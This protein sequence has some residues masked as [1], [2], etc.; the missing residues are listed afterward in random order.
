M[1]RLAVF[2]AVAF[3]F[4][5]LPAFAGS[6]QAD[7][8]RSASSDSSCRAKKKAKK[9]AAD[10]KGKKKGKKDDKKPYGFEL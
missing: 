7:S 6:A 3:V 10:S 1:K 2:L 9:Q 5:G 4:V 8:V